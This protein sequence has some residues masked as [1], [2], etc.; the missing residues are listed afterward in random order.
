MT[1]SRS[2]S[3]SDGTILESPRSKKSLSASPPSLQTNSRLISN[4]SSLGLNK[5]GSRIEKHT[6]DLEDGT[7]DSA[8]EFSTSTLALKSI[9]YTFYIVYAS[10]AFSYITEAETANHYA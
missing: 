4:T 2:D 1:S 8:V 6:G 10:D 7:F 9:G 3:D 5:A